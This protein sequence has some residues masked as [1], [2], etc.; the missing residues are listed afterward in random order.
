MGSTLCCH[1][2]HIIFSTKN[3]ERSISPDLAPRL[4][5]Y[6]GGTA[7]HRDSA[8]IAAGGV[9][10]HI[11]LLVDLHQS[12]ALADLV[13]DL[14]SNSSRWMHDD[15]SKREFGWQTGYAAFS[16]SKS[17]VEAVKNYID[18][19]REHHAERK[20]ED[21]LVEFLRR[22]EVEYDPRYIFA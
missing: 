10:D 18:H 21:E 12:C 3:R 1:L 14:K 5:E 13:R 6:L 16:V 22:H 7:R 20:F 11:H 4:Y 15:L 2:V 8:I 17:S 19:Q 9:E